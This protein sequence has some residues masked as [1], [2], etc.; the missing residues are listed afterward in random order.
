[1]QGAVQHGRGGVSQEAVPPAGEW[2]VSEP[3]RMLVMLYIGPPL[4]HS[5]AVRI[6]ALILRHAAFASGN[7]IVSL[8]PLVV[9]AA[10]R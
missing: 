10:L 1:M 7:T 5:Y 6:T 2:G 9:R 8:C 3:A 4:L